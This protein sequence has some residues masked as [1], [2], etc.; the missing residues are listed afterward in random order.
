[1]CSRASGTYEVV[2]AT[3]CELFVKFSGI[4]VWADRSNIKSGPRWELSIGFIIAMWKTDPR[5]KI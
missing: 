2:C 1:M 4:P 5:A 3:W